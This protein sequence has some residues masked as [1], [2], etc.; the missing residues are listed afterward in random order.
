MQQLPDRDESPDPTVD[1]VVLDR[2]AF[3]RDTAGGGAALALASLFP[4][5]CSATYP[6]ATAD[7]A[8][9]RSL[10]DKEYAI[11]RAAAEALLVGVPV[12][13]KVV[14]GRIDHELAA[15]GD[16]MRADF[17]TVLGLIEH[18]T[19]LGGHVHRFT[20]LK[21]ADRL[22]YLNGWGHSRFALR[23]AAFYALK[24]FI[25][26]FAYVEPAT[27]GITR[28]AGPW[29]ER[30]KVAARPIDFGTIA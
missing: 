14:A 28:F 1:R 20:K 15:A 8:E 2:R 17:K 5:G 22:S 30:L 7:A 19:P 11:T 6:H 24:G 13:A 29:P 26:Y 21:P 3:L 10:T 23:R 27:R 9:L 12:E 16:P 18:L 4:A 25:T